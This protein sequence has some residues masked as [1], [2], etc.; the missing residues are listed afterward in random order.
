MTAA[1]WSSKHQRR[2]RTRQRLDA[3][4]RVLGVGALTRRRM[5]TER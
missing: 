3:G 5:R 2:A 1:T 4:R